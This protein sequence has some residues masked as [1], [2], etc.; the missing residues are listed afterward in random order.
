M[1][2][3]GG[4]EAEGGGAIYYME[5]DLYSYHVVRIGGKHVF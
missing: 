5:G 2:G 3:G 4:R 1:C